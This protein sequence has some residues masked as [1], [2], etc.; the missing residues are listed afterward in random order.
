LRPD[1]VLDDPPADVARSAP[2]PSAR[3][4][5]KVDPDPAQAAALSDAWD[6]YAER[7]GPFTG[8]TKAVLVPLNPPGLDPIDL[9]SQSV[10]DVPLP[11]QRAAGHV[12]TLGADEMALQGIIEAEIYHNN[13]SGTCGN[14][15]WYLPR[16][17]EEGSRLTVVPPPSSVPPTPR[18][19]AA[20][21]IYIGKAEGVW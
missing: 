19:I 13:P 10:P 12:E 5:F 8:R 1:F 15:D 3:G 14:C 18:W 16:F 2:Q 4:P 6:D 9:T 11:Y 21:R 20:P 17:L 7:L